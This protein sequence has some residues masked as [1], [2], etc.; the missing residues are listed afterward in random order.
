M[1][2][3][4]PTKRKFLDNQILSQW[5]HFEAQLVDNNIWKKKSKFF[6]LNFWQYW[7]A[8]IKANFWWFLLLQTP[9][10]VTTLKPFALIECSTTKSYLLCYL[11]AV[12]VGLS[13]ATMYDND[14]SFHW[15]P[16]ETFKSRTLISWRLFVASTRRTTELLVHGH[17]VRDPWVCFLL[18]CWVILPAIDGFAQLIQYVFSY[19][20]CQLYSFAIDGAWLYV[21]G[22]E[23]GIFPHTPSSLCLAHSYV[24]GDDCHNTTQAPVV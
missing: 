13:V 15:L 16:W 2:A 24:L 19:A 4:T 14:H 22:D 17:I 18:F 21:A 10:Q 3:F 11:K 8:F 23:D 7:F 6:R 12:T 1:P 5:Y 20:L 9:H